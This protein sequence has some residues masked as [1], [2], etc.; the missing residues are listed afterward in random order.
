MTEE[1]WK[2]ILN[3]NK[4]EISSL[5]KVRNYKTKNIIKSTIRG[6]GYYGVELFINKKQRHVN[7]IH[8]LV[9]ETFLPNNDESKKFIVHINNN[10]SD[11]LQNHCYESPRINSGDDGQICWES[12]IKNYIYFI[13]LKDLIQIILI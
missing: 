2:P 8:E 12:K 7:Y 9:A 13:I 5:G 6:G 10:K 1:I 3:Y 11:N 4:Y